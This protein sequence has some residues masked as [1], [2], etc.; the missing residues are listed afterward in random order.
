[1]TIYTNTTDDLGWYVVEVTATLDVFSLLGDT[2][3]SNDPDHTPP[4][5]NTW[6]H[7]SATGQKVY[8]TDNVPSD[9]LYK[10]SFNVTVGV[11]QVNTTSIT[12][13]NTAPYLLPI[14]ERTHK[15]IFGQAW[16]YELG[17]VNDFEG[18]NVQVSV[19]LR[20]AKD[21]IQFN[22]STRTLWIDA[23]VTN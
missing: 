22:N 12:E 19:E 16:Q 9:F 8:G 7:D 18:D 20:N 14:P 2:I 4:F 21:I 17:A 1:M 6:L 5:L 13:D 23:G 11:I 15:V 10:H 3:T